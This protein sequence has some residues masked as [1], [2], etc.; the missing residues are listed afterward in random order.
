MIRFESFRHV[1]AETR[2]ILRSRFAR[3][4]PVSRIGHVQT[5][6]DEVFD[7]EVVLALFQHLKETRNDSL[8][9]AKEIYDSARAMGPAQP[10]FDELLTNGWLV[11]AWGRVYVPVNIYIAIKRSDTTTMPAFLAWMEV[12]HECTFTWSG[13]HAE[14]VLSELVDSVVA[15]TR[16]PDH[17]ACTS[18]VWVAGRLWERRSGDVADPLMQLRDWLDAWILL[19]YPDIVPTTVW[20]KRDSDAFEQTALQILEENAG[21]PSWDRYRERCVKQMAHAALQPAASYEGYVPKVPETL[22]AR[23]VWLKSHVMQHPVHWGLEAWNRASGLI[24]IL[25]N[26]ASEADNSPAPHQNGARVLELAIQHPDVLNTVL[27]YAASQPTLLVEM[28]LKPE[29]SA[30]ACLLVSEWNIHAGAW[31]RELVTRDNEAARDEAFAD[32]VSILGEHLRAE[33]LP[34]NEVAALL[35]EMHA[36]AKPG[37]VNELAGGEAMLAALRAEL[38]QQSKELLLEVFKSLVQL[39]GELKLGHSAFAAALDVLD[40]GQLGN[41][42]PADALLAAYVESIQSDDYV[43]SASR[44]STNGAAELYSLSCKLAEAEQARFLFPFDVRQRLANAENIYSARDSVARSLRVHMRILSRAVVGQPDIVPEELLVALMKTVRVGAIGHDEKGRVAAMAATYEVDPYR[45]QWDRPLSADLAAALGVLPT[46]DAKRLLAAILETDEP[47]FLAQLIGVVSPAFKTDIE[48]RIE[49]LVPEEAGESRMVTERFLR[50]ESL[51][52]AGALNA[53]AAYIASESELPQTL[54]ARFALVRLRHRLQLAL[55]RGDWDTVMSAIVPDDMPMGD[56]AEARDV[57]LFYQGAAQL[58]RE[59]GNAEYA[60]QIFAQLHK[61]RPTVAAYGYNLFA[62]QVSRVIR[63]DLFVRL[64]D[65]QLR[66][67]NQ[68]LADAEHMERSFNLKEPQ[69]DAYLGNKALM[70]LATGR[71]TEA[72]RILYPLY[73][74]RMTDRV[75]ACRAVALAR[76]G[77]G[78]EALDTLDQAETLLGSSDLLIETRNFL[79]DGTSVSL[80]VEVSQSDD[81]LPRIKDALNDLWRLDPM[82]QAEVLRGPPTAFVTFIT[83]QVRYAA[84]SI[85]SLVPMMKNVV[86]DSCEDDI[87]AIVRELLASRFAFLG[88]SVPDQSKGGYTGKGNAGERDLLIKKDTSEL[89]ALEAV[90][91]DRP[92]G[93]QWTKAEL[94]S[95]F[96]KLLGYSTCKL[97]FHLTYAYKGALSEIVAELKALAQHEAPDNFMFLRTDN[98]D[99][100]DSRPGGFFARYKTN[101]AEVTVVFLVLNLGQEDQRKAAKLAESNSAR[102]P[103]AKKA[104]GGEVKDVVSSDTQ[105]SAEKR[106]YTRKAAKKTNAGV[107]KTISNKVGVE[108][109]KRQD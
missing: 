36:R 21:F 68:A 66:R 85:V 92:P 89:V 101:D 27:F 95:H 77:R 19:G 74:A 50:I 35:S 88:W 48:K 100:T 65:E 10:R 109:A 90:V 6:P 63:G 8:A 105:N 41:D 104:V 59:N 34:A 94:R 25:L 53:A 43:L 96:Q 54:N 24:R 93:T 108:K 22:V 71:N 1:P 107:A 28:L 64:R 97:F 84:S 38:V 70:L 103:K 32:A 33:R 14:G 83:E 78:K 37:N 40:A 67:A 47:A 76:M 9:N 44:I 23:A 58:K 102:A 75:A 60:E 52:N 39:R 51:L 72:E 98:L 56:K 16:R 86:I 13:S 20:R 17:L 31:D 26:E 7:D 82:Q 81:P 62:A 87:S 45:G 99:V 12:R 42:V 55:L 69:A 91:C 49:A 11:E 4:L 29:A 5:E 2:R 30:L 80:P 18:P 3:N 106:P 79:S 61:R 15:K 46:T 73:I 57:I